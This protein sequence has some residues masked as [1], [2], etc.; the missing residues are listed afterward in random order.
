MVTLANQLRQFFGLTSRAISTVRSPP[1]DRII[2]C[3][4]I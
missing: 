3:G 2:T 4:A 1:D